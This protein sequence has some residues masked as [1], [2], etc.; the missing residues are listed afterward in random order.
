M[1][2]LEII[3]GLWKSCKHSAEFPYTLHPLSPNDK[4]LHNYSAMIK[5]RYLTLLQY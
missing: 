4:I 2:Y 1:F 5:T 3:L